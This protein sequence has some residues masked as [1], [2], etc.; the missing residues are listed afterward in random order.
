MKLPSIEELAEVFDEPQEARKILE[1]SYN[2]LSTTDAGMK[3]IKE[4]YND[5]MHF[6]LCMTVLNSIQNNLFG[7]ECLLSDTNEFAH[8]LNT[9]DSYNATIIYFR[10]NY[11]VQSVADFIENQC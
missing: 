11:R 9:G 1:M 4:C 6:D 7:M 2:Q 8:Y 10:D 3:R 5:P